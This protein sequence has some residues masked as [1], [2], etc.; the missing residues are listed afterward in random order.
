[1]YKV[2]C[3][4]LTRVWGIVMP[5]AARLLASWRTKSGFT[6]KKLDF[7]SICTGVCTNYPTCSKIDCALKNTVAFNI[8]GSVVAERTFHTLSPLDIAMSH[9]NPINRDSKRR[10]WFQTTL[11]F[12]DSLFWSG[13]STF[14]SQLF[15]WARTK[16][17]VWPLR[18][19]VCHGGV[20]SILSMSYLDLDTFSTQF[21]IKVRRACV[22]V[23]G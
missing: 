18:H 21:E 7:V 12:V 1:M 16:V 9:W 19:N 22:S 6:L 5:P 10:R 15:S 2:R 4:T 8:C 20:S 11:R 17:N 14:I 13:A 23:S 3:C